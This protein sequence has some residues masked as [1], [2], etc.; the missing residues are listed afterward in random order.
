MLAYRILLTM[1][2]VF[3]V[4]A[5]GYL[6]GRWRRPD[7]GLANQLNM[8]IF[9]PALLFHVLAG[10]E[11]HIAEYQALALGGLLVILGSGLLVLPIA[12]L[13]R[14]HPKTLLP[15]MMFTNTGNIGLPLAVL[16]FGEAALPGAVVLFIVENT[17]HFSLGAYIMDRH[18]GIARL[19][20]MPIILATI[21]GLLVSL[22]DWKIPRL[23]ALPVEM[24]GQV[25]VPLLLFALGV[26]LVQVDFSDWKAGLLGAVLCPLSG[27]LLVLALLPFL[28]LPA[29]QRNLFIVF[30]ALPPAVLNY[31][32]AEQYR[33]EPKRVASI[34][35][36]GN[37]AG[38]I[39]L[40]TALAFVL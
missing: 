15:P 4:I 25:S 38:I 36:L 32:V 34:V 9:L 10:K 8:D 1:F 23:I 28:D 3:A 21:A 2:P 39:T 5:V 35:M 18:A 26:R 20:R 27:V 17:L 30:G 19:F 40:P 12:R 22:L 37:L 6:Y 31:I 7:M 16:A 33:Q 29:L 11:F 14:L 24:L 13:T